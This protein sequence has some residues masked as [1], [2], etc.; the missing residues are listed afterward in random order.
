MNGHWSISSID[1]VAFELDGTVL[2]GRAR[3][4]DT[5]PAIE[6]ETARIYLKIVAPQ[7]DFSFVAQLD[8]GAAWTVFDPQL[9][10]ALNVD[11]L[12]AV[13]VT[14]STRLGVFT[15]RLA[16]ATLRFLADEGDSVD[17]EATIFVSPEW[18]AGRNFIAYTGTLERLRFAV[19]PTENDI[20]YG[21]LD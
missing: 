15:G 21:L 4:L 2:V 10:E 14:L 12:E 5:D 20:Y 7:H 19:D 3:F 8:T 11:P 9:T 16:R 6:S 17:I 18:P 13:T 1:A